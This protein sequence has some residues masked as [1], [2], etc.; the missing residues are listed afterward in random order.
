MKTLKITLLL[1][2]FT[3]ILLMGCEIH[4]ELSSEP[5]KQVVIEQPIDTVAVPSDTP[6]GP[7]IPAGWNTYRNETYGFE[8][9]YPSTYQALDDADNLYGWTNGVVLLYNQGQS[10][11]IAIQAWNSQ[12]EYES[13]LGT[14]MARITVHTIG[15]RFITVFNITEEPENAAVIA[16]FR[17]I[18]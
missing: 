17:A 3:S 2:I 6:A 10:Y 1:V 4:I 12:P 13:E 16:T 14:E 5:T 8:I 18:N 9:S 15:S 7:S 11:D